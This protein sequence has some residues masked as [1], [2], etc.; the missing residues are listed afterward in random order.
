MTE[1]TM[2][3]ETDPIALAEFAFAVLSDHLKAIQPRELH[4]IPVVAF[5]V[6][7]AGTWHLATSATRA[8]CARGDV[9][10][11]SLRIFC[12]AQ[13]LVRLLS[14]QPTSEVVYSGDVASLRPLLSALAER[15]SILSLRAARTPVK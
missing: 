2:T 7:G 4:R 5:D 14:G 13:G 1:E 15:G 8:T 6:K 11:A 12:T 10:A 3:E 9:Q